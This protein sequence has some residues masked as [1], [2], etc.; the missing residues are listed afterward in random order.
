MFKKKY[1]TTALQFPLF[2][3]GGVQK[4]STLILRGGCNNTWLHWSG[5]ERRRGDYLRDQWMRESYAAMGRLSARG[6]FVHVYL[7]G[8]Y[9]GLYNLVERPDAQFLAANDH[10]VPREYDSR[11]GDHVLSGD[12]E[13]WKKLFLLTNA[14]LKSESSYQAIQELL[15]VPAFIDFM[16]LNCYGAN[17]DWDHASNWYAGRRREPAG[18]FQF[19]VWDG[20]RTLETVDGNI[21]SGDDDQSPLR[22]FQRLR[23]NGD[24]RRQFAARVRLHCFNGGALTPESAAKRWRTH[25][26][27]LD[28]A[29][30]AESVRWGDYRRD[31][32][33]YR[34]G[35]YELY[36]RD[37]HWRPEM[38]RLA[39]DFF[40]KRTAVLLEQF[41]AAGL[42]QAT[43][44]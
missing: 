2:G 22:L 6:R 16:I 30:V 36:T 44:P 12:T 38:A 24:F 15:D 33:P 7:N 19:L 34:V 42:F 5:E 26:T 27:E 21:L 32:H 9:W 17:G 11:N 41:R 39:K 29:I 4:F 28:T 1:G 31:V 18:K 35:P 3:T 43:S 23:E 37:D 14:G 20:E 13:A 10:G 8:L 25:M 40:P